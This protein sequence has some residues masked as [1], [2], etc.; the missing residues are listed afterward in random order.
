MGWPVEMDSRPKSSRIA[1]LSAPLDSV[2]GLTTFAARFLMLLVAAAVSGLIIFSFS[3]PLDTLEERLGALAWTFSPNT[4]T[5]QRLT[6]VAIDERSL[7][8]VGPWPWPRETLA[9]LVMAIDNAGAQLQLHDIVYQEAKPGDQLF[10]EALQNAS[11]AVIAQ[12]PILMPAAEGQP[13][14][15][16]QMSH[17]LS[18]LDC[19]SSAVLPKASGYLAP[20]SGLAAVAKGHITPIIASD[21]SVRKAPALVCVN[22]QAYP[23]LALTAFLQGSRSADWP[24]TLEPGRSLLDPS[25]VLSL[26]DYPGLNI[27]LDSEGNMRV[28]YDNDPSVYRAISAADVLNGTADAGLLENTWVLVGAT[29]FS[30]GDIVPTPYSGAVPGVELQARILG[31]LLDVEVPYTPRGV[32]WIL[33]LISLFFAAGLNYLAGYRGRVAAIG[34]PVAVLLLPL[35]SLFLHMQLLSSLNVWLGWIYPA[36]FGISAASLLLL[37]E[38]GRV[39]LE[40]G[41]VFGNL[42]SYLPEEI[43][44]E[45]AFSLPSSSINAQRRNVTLLNADLRNFSA[46]AEIRPPEESAAVL[47]FFFTKATEVIEH[48]G[49]RVHEFKGDSLLAVWE[50]NDSH[51][52]QQALGAAEEMQFVVYNSLIQNHSPSGLEPLALGI[53]IEQGPVLIG[54]IGPAHR[55][56]H[57]LLGETVGIVLRIQEMTA[58]L[59]HPILLGE[60]V[61]RQL[62]DEGLESQGSYLL[63][64]L[65][66]PHVLFAPRPNSQQNQDDEN[67]NQP[68]LKLLLGGRR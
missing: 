40:R 20:N 41:R 39:R 4:E 25:Y 33:A 31:S 1:F 29:A 37:Q 3:S 51:S 23:S 12:V 49:G 56:S 55:R 36:V 6:V 63:N 15:S 35:L 64:G 8:A 28:S 42:N 59:A 43:A 7:A 66:I 62:E 27:P 22:G 61:A 5:E 18:G 65:T 54:S 10:L 32:G 45:I 68:A 9:E 14:T 11:S 46:F 48:H 2:L 19:G 21:G 34:L 26:D 50:G 16:G 17:A 47:H 13:V 38:Q 58:D 67:Q 24:V 57:T 52:G 60:C 30:M 53:G 44:R